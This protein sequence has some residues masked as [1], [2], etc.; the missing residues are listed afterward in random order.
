MENL[1]DIE[2]GQLNQPKPELDIKN[3]IEIQSENRKIKQ[4]DSLEQLRKELIE[5]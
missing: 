3:E 2:D 1:M 4:R 5:R